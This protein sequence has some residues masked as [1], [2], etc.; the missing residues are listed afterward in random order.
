MLMPGSLPICS[1]DTASTMLSAF[2]L[3]AVE[4]SI[5]LMKPETWMAS[6]FLAF[7]GLV[8]SVLLASAGV[9]DEA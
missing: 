9:C 2:R 5:L 7:L 4:F 6:S 8:V 1:D 3:I